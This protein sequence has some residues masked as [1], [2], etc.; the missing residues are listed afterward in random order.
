MITN[1]PICDSPLK[2]EIYSLIGIIGTVIYCSKELN[3]NSDYPNYH[4]RYVTSDSAAN[5]DKIICYDFIINEVH[6]KG[7]NSLLNTYYNVQPYTEI[8]LSHKSIK[9]PF[10]PLLNP[11]EI[12]NFFHKITNLIPY[13]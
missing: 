12:H 7:N 3:K 11:K 10:V 4:F 1:C 2:Y 13:S 5:F 9:L 6:I 8:I